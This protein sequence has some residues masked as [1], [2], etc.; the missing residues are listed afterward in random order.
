MLDYI[1][2]CHVISH[3]MNKTYIYIYIYIEREIIVIILY[4]E[5]PN[6]GGRNVGG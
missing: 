3:H 6:G 2:L 4:R 5:E 1:T